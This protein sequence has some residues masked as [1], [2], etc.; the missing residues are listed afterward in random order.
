MASLLG[1]NQ[2]CNSAYVGNVTD[3]RQS[4]VSGYVKNPVLYL[5]KDILQGFSSKVGLKTFKSIARRQ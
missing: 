3:S 1:F 4:W 5:N 2:T